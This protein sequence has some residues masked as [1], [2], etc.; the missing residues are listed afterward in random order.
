MI[1]DPSR[2]QGAPNPGVRIISGSS[3]TTRARG[4]MPASGRCTSSART[5]PAVREAVV[6]AAA[7]CPRRTS[8]AGFKH[9]RHPSR[10]DPESSQDRCL[11]STQIARKFI[12]PPKSVADPDY[13]TEDALLTVRQSTMAAC[14]S[15]APGFDIHDPSTLQRSRT[16]RGRLHARLS[17][18]VRVAGH[19]A[20]IEPSKSKRVSRALSRFLLPTGMGS[21]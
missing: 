4:Q 16:G 20:S 1:L 17:F 14:G 19:P 10:D 7:A 13:S 5:S 18:P 15:V 8:A 12:D 6:S 3:G 11:K 9:H 2:R 21:S